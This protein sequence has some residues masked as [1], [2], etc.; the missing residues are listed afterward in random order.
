MDFLTFRKHF[1]PP[2][3]T[4]LTFLEVNPLC[5]L[6]KNASAKS[7][8]LQHRN[9]WVGMVMGMLQHCG[10]KLAGGTPCLSLNFTSTSKNIQLHKR[11]R[12]DLAKQTVRIEISVAVFMS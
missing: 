6:S 1:Q 3:F 4:V 7:V 2:F 12:L 10:W 5:N 8:L 11:G 9:I